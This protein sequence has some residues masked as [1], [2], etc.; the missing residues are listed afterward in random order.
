MLAMPGDPPAGDGWTGE[1]KHDGYRAI[2]Y[3]EPGGLRVLS[4]NNNSLLAQFPEVEALSTVC[5]RH[6]VVLD[7]EIVAVGRDGVP[8]F[9]LLQ[10][11]RGAPTRWS[12][13]KA[14]VQ[15]FVF[16]LLYL[17]GRSLLGEPYRLRRQ[18]LI[19]LQLPGVAAVQVPPAF[20]DTEPEVLLEVA[21]EYGFEGAVFKRANSVYLPGRRSRTWIKCPLTETQEVVVGGWTPGEGSRASSFGSLLLGA[22]DAQGRLIYIGRVGSS[23]SEAMLQEIRRTLD[24]LTA[25]ESPFSEPVPREH[26]RTARWVRPELV[27]EVT[28]R[29]WTSGGHLRHAVWRGRRDDR[30]PGSVT[31]PAQ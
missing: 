1:F 14:P 15:Y 22:H 16:D 12:R 25:P 8:D 30:S 26:A 10:H 28:F 20:P 5:G 7:G 27:G 17:D 21:R 29:S 2:A 13:T 3:V 11:R 19:D 31:L 9:S 18:L 24:R 4:R 23:L 6:S